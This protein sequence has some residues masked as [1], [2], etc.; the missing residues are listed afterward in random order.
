MIDAIV[1]IEM[2]NLLRRG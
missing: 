1:N 2:D